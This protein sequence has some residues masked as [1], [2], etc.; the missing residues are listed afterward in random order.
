MKRVKLDDYQKAVII[1]S[2][3]GDA[4]LEANLV[5]DQLPHGD[6]SFSR[7]ERVRAVALRDS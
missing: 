7:P 3:L 6:S 5:K 4:Y 1:G 2:I